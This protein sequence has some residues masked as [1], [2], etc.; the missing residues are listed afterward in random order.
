MDI[1][2]EALAQGITPAIVVALYLI[3]V[4]IIDNKK[5]KAQ[6]KI[7]SELVKSITNIST[8][9]N[10]ITKST[11]ERDKDKCKAAITDSM[12]HSAYKLIKFVVDTLINNHID[13]NKETILAN[14]K[15]ITNAEY[16]TTY[17]TLSLYELSGEKVST[18]LKKEWIGEVEQAIIASIYNDKLNVEDKILNFSNK[19]NL[20]FQSYITYVINN[21]IKG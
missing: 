15:N 10:T 9:I 4:K 7:S 14:I 1:L 18:H 20:K 5:D 2:G 21:S 19:I 8:F 11:I 6:A 16:Y 3:V 12:N 13:I 17:S